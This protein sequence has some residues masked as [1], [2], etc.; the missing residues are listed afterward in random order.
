[1]PKKIKKIISKD[2]IYRLPYIKVISEHTYMLKFK[3]QG[4]EIKE[5]H[6][7]VF[8]ISCIF[9]SRTLV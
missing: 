6:V 7:I 2:I 5:I 4:L 3:S 1:M 8:T 9:A